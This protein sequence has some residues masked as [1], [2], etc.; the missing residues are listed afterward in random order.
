[1]RKIF[2]ML[3]VFLSASVVLSSCLNSDET[4]A[5]LYDDMA[6]TSFTLGT[7]NRYTTITSSS[8]L[9]PEISMASCSR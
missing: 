8:T 4:E 2:Y 3:A 6:I 9:L 1:M 5:T 7:L